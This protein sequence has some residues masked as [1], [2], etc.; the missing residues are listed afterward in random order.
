[1][2]PSHDRG[3]RSHAPA[4]PPGTAS[5]GRFA[6]GSDG[7][8]RRLELLPLPRDEPQPAP[9][10]TRKPARQDTFGER[11]DEAPP[12]EQLG[13]SAWRNTI[14]Q[15]SEKRFAW[16]ARRSGPRRRGTREEG[17]RASTRSARK[18]E[19]DESTCKPD[20]VRGKA[21]FRVAT[22][23]L[24][25][26]S[27]TDSS[28]LPAGIGRAALEHLRRRRRRPLDLAPGGVYRATPV[29]RGAGGLLHHPFTLTRPNRPGGLLSV[30]LS[31]GSPLVAV[32]NH[33]AL[34]SPDFPR[35]EGPAAAARSTRPLP[36]LRTRD[37]PTT[38]PA[39]GNGHPGFPDPSPPPTGAIRG[40][41]GTG[42]GSDP[43]PR[44]HSRCEV[45]LTNRTEA[46]PS[47]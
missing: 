34:W 27:P 42:R 1:M 43:C 33:P 2:K 24:G 7:G 45:S 6:N 46:L 10:T 12:I 32:S 20:P 15:L 36:Q 47:G 44:D 16:H 26:P 17:P 39:P 31:R 41:G 11:G 25:L 38:F 23:H 22:I 14:R 21:T 13:T 28:G 37:T 5:E 8:E 19:A 9:P 30:A 35:R 29:T 4:S 40:S 18:R 3:L